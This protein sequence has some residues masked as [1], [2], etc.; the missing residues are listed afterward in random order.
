M[1]KREGREIWPERREE[2]LFE[3]IERISETYTKRKSWDNKKR[4]K[5]GGGGRNWG[6]KRGNRKERRLIEMEKERERERGRL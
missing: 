1:R 2:E 3:I 5:L 6:D 4:I